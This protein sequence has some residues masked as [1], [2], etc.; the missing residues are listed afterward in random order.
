MPFS[1]LIP[2]LTT[3]MPE[4]RGRLTANASMAELTWL[5]VGGPAQVLFNPA[6][7]DDL[8]YFL[9]NLPEEI[10]VTTVGVGSN[11]LVRDGGVEGVVI[12]LGGRLLGDIAVLGDRQIQAGTAALDARVAKAAADAGIGSLAFYAGIPGSIGGAL[13]MNAGAHGG[14]TKDVL[15]YANGVTRDGDFVTL[16]N[17]EMGF[18]YRHCAAL[19]DIIFTSALFEGTAS[20]VEAERAAIEHVQKT[21][22]ATQPIKSRT[23][24]STFKNPPGTSSWKVIDAAGL[25]GFRV[26]GA[27]M[28]VM[29]ANFLINDANATAHDVELLGETVRRRVF[30]HSGVKL[31]WEIKRIGAFAPGREVAPAFKA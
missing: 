2:D 22:E 26:G 13:R 20:T 7:E 1:D 3:R 14:E 27:H 12:R 4:L 23:G 9:A 18:T 6:D 11:L 15:V 19:E 10:A 24:G 5:R 17:A 30:E 28:S 8:A 21:R 29:H 16:T 25:R 31:D